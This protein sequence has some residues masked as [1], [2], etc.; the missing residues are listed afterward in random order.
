MKKALVFLG[1]IIA[2]FIFYYIQTDF[3]SFFS[4]AGIVP[5]TFIILVLFVRIICR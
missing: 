3:F 2:F 5:N 1:I 4:I